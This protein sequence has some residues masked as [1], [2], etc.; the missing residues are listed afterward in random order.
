M[1]F[2]FALCQLSVIEL[3][4]YLSCIIDSIGQNR[5]TPFFGSEDFPP[6]IVES[7]NCIQQAG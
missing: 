4:Y 5:K 2:Y 1:G 3:R 6:F 7:I